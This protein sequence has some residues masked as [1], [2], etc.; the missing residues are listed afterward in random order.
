MAE[1]GNIKIECSDCG[2]QFDVSPS[3]RNKMVECGEC[4]SQFRVNEDSMVK[5][6]KRHFP[7]EKTGDLSMFS[8]KIDSVEVSDE[9]NFRTAAYDQKIDQNAVMPLG[10]KRV[11]A[12]FAGIL[13]SLAVIL[14]YVLGHDS[15]KQSGLMLDV[16]SDK[17]YVLSGFAALLTA[18]LLVYGCRKNRLVGII[19][20]V[21]LGGAVLALPFYYGEYFSPKTQVGT[22]SETKEVSKEEDIYEYKSSLG[23]GAVEDAIRR[24][25]DADKVIA[26][27]VIGAKRENLDTIE[28]FLTRVIKSDDLPK[29]LSSNRRVGDEDANLFLYT[30]V[31]ISLDDL[32]VELA[33]VGNVRRVRDEL[34]VIEVDADPEKLVMRSASILQDESSP[35]FY[36]ANYRELAH[37][38][39]ERQL[40]AIKRLGT[41]SKVGRQADVV[42]RLRGKLRVRDYP[43]HQEAVTTLLKWST[44]ERNAVSEV[45]Q[46]CSRLM[47]LEQDVPTEY[48]DYLIKFGDD[49]LKPVLLY[50]WK[51]E[52]LNMEATVLRAGNR[53]VDTIVE[54][55]PDLDQSYYMSAAS[56]LRKAGRMDSVPVIERV[57]GKAD[58]T[59]KK[60]LRAAI[61][62][63]KSR[64]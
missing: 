21:V 1:E 11:L 24:S 42:D 12:I 48:L 53:G 49:N 8:K 58:A 44:Q 29:S 18:L 62:E 51:R 36:S 60:A 7:G 57:M 13:L 15:A 35:T 16:T 27:A 9:V 14:V 20:S 40:A 30:N 2:Q 31:G 59:S 61:D 34:R 28:G 22:R 33:A 45:Q 47:A 19:L 4:K 39:M 63:I 37:V 23:Y 6:T 46:L 26:V 25:G 55:L 10:P 56:I 3:L 32:A 38:D 54:S 17:K 50:E 5:V 41:A 43:Y 52:S 64:G